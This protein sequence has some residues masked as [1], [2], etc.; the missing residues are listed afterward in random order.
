MEE[1]FVWHPVGT[2]LATE[3]EYRERVAQNLPDPR[4][5]PVGK[6]PEPDM[7]YLVT[8]INGEVDVDEFD[9]DGSNDWFCYDCGSVIAW[10]QFPLFSP[11]DESNPF[12]HLCKECCPTENRDFLVCDIDGKYAVLP[13]NVQKEAFMAT[14]CAPLET[15]V[16]FAELPEPYQEKKPS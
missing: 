2:R 13:F 15:A 11:D 5:V 6:W 9:I 12:W 4:T 7:V 16:A 8:M 1:N 3:E 10:M 14:P